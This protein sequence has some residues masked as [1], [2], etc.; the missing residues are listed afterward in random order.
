MRWWGG[1]QP[2]HRL[3][4]DK[5]IVPAP[6]LQSTK[7][8]M[9]AQLPKFLRVQLNVA[10]AFQPELRFNIGGWEYQLYSV[11]FGSKSHFTSNIRFKERWFHYDGQGHRRFPQRNC[12]L[13]LMEEQ[14]AKY[15]VPFRPGYAAISL[16]YMRQDPEGQATFGHVSPVGVAEAEGFR[17]DQCQYASMHTVL[18]Y[19]DLLKVVPE[20]VTIDD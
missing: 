11:V 8:P 17:V 16:R 19:G 13:K 15:W 3:C 18:D 1:P 9:K 7:T 14:D 5:K 12:N 4:K 10:S 6:F 2:A 20:R